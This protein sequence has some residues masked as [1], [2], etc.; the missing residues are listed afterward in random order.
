MEGE[1]VFWFALFL[2]IHSAGF[3]ALNL[4]KQDELTFVF[5]Y[6]QIANLKHQISNK[7]QIPIHLSKTSLEIQIS[8]IEVYL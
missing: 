2:S 7:S 3:F 5:E 6:R 1:P 8:V 4:D